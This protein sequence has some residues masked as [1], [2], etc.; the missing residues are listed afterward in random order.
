MTFAEIQELYAVGKITIKSY[1]SKMFEKYAELLDYRKLIK[2]SRV[3]RIAI[4]EEEV[5]FTITNQS[6]KGEPYDINMVVDGNDAAA[7]PVD[8]L[9]TA[10][11]YEPHEFAM[12]N[13]LCSYL[14]K[15][16][17]FLDVGANLGWYTLNVCKQYPLWKGYA[18]EPIPET[19]IRLQRNVEI[20]QLKNCKLYQ[21]G[22]SNENKIV[23]FYYDVEASGAS[24][25]ADLREAES[26]VKVGCQVNRMDDFVETERLDRI[27]FIKCDV[28]G[29]EL[30]V[31]QGGIRSIKRYKP[32][33]FS[34][35]L[36]KWSA[37]FNYHPNDMIY[38][39]EDAGYQCFVLAENNKLKRFG[40]VDE[41][42]VE[43]N[44]FFLCPQV[45]KKMIEDLCISL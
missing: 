13:I 30:F 37:K 18:F 3:S 16:S 43:T 9:S 42:T 4:D 26:T 14:E 40:Y 33:I 39:L 27:D 12:V 21:A 11:G 45:H 23:S 44:Y 2:N 17:V 31:F 22:L 38:L 28:E 8:M 19:F 41:N 34:E 36:R 10:D 24:S 7:V 1:K 25:M 35:M 6:V 15:D 20:N 29:S 32:V 5:V